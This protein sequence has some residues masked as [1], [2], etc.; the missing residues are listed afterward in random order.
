MLYPAAMVA[1]ASYFRNAGA[2][3]FISTMYLPLLFDMTLVRFFALTADSWVS[4]SNSAA[5]KPPGASWVPS[6]CGLI[7]VSVVIPCLSFTFFCL[8]AVTVAV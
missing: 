5:D 6:S 4:T 1:H 8:V 7:S 2:S 3:G